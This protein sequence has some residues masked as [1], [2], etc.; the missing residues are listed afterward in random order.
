[1]NFCILFKHF[2]YLIFENL[3]LNE[4]NVKSHRWSLK[5][6]YENACKVLIL[7]SGT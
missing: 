1:M 7:I 4:I 2:T 5:M 3:N 6:P